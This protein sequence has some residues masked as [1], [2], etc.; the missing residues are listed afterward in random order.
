MLHGRLLLPDLTVCCSGHK[1]EVYDLCW[2]PSSNGMRGGHESAFDPLSR[3][4]A[5][6]GII[7]C[8][9]DKEVIIWDSITG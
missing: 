8:S 5:S 3:V 4:V 9:I 1:D 6:S 7:P 2:S